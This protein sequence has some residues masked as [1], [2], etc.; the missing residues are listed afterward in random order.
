L[1]AHERAYRRLTRQ[2]SALGF[3]VKGSV[4][5]RSMQCGQ[6]ACRCRRNPR[7]RHGPYY[8]WTSKVGGKTVT[9]VLS[10]EEGKLYLS[11]AQNR[12]RLEAIVER[13]YRV[14]AQVALARTGR[15]PPILRQR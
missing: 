9:W 8:W 1:A 14:S 5:V 11:W 15:L 4:Q 10:E 2:L 12:Q 3:V 7:F 6:A 13:L